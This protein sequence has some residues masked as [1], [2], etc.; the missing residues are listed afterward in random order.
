MHTLPDVVALQ[1]RQAPSDIL[2]R[3]LREQQ[4]LLDSAG[5]GILFIRHRRVVRC[6]PRYAEIFQLH[7]PQAAVGH[8]SETLH[9]SREAFRALGRAAYPVLARGETYRTE[10]QMRRSNGCLFWT[11]LTGRLINP[12]DSSEGSIWIVDDIDEQKRSQAELHAALREKQVLFDNAMVGI[13]VLRDRILARCNRHFEQ[14]LG[15][16]PGELVGR[17]SRQ[18]YLSESDWQAAGEHCYAPLALGRE[19]EGQMTLRAKDGRAVAV[20]VRSRPLDPADLSQGTLWIV[21]DVSERL[22]VQAQLA[23]MHGAL[24]QQVRDRTRELRETVAD[25]HREI[26]QRKRDQERIHWL[27][28][29][30]VL[31]GLPN[32]LL[33]TE[34][35]EQAVEAA[36]RS[37]APLS[38]IF[39]DLDNF[40]HVND[41][42]GH[43]VGDAL[44]VEMARR[45][46]RTVR[47][48][49]TVARLSGDEFVLI[50]PGANAQG[51]A[52]VAS[53]MQEAAR[54]PV[55][56]GHHEL[57]VSPSMGI[58]LFPEHGED[59]E[60]L[61]QAADTAMYRAKAE[62][63]NNFR[64]FTPRMQE[65]SAQ[66]LQLT[67]ALSRALERGQFALHYQPQVSA[68]TGAISGVE[69]LLRW[70]HPELGDISPADFIPVAE[71]SGQIVAIGEWVLDTALAQL[72]RWRQRGLSGFTMSVNLSAA[73][74][75]HPQLPELVA[76]LLERHG[77]AGDSLELELTENVA[78]GDP[79]AAA[80]I[81]D[82]LHAH[83]VGLAIDDFGTGYSSLSQLKRFRICRLK[84]D[85]SFVRD[86]GQDR[87]D[88]ALVSAIVRMAQALGMRTTAEGVETPQQL[89][90]L[91]GEGC[92]ELQGFHISRP[93]PAE[94]VEPFLLRHQRGARLAPAPSQARPGKPSP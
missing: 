4:T 8:S 91:R 63:R 25:L 84:I 5:V 9:P 69:A 51:A 90:L 78:I 75:R 48:R 54:A 38:I 29:Y 32:R 23:Q 88:H 89:E 41:S 72:Q 49:D 10:W 42:L 66:A 21:L 47:D 52:R 46:R 34:R 73:Q 14:I 79:E 82:Q 68:A 71:D 74:F 39:L 55:Q 80:R 53:K 50:L 70:R 65:Q 67:N 12:E 76:Q 93:L 94:Q 16:G 58:A 40:K 92:T 81:M 62:G 11:H 44:L 28:H 6:N 43:R 36:R 35:G 45:L 1:Q 24:E 13:V 56:L 30:D 86:L 27:A 20:E 83:G 7:S 2:K 85:R 60:S 57:S 31:T 18:W 22:R 15:Y 3:A 19:F 59:F 77:L 37:G 17:S 61:I 26:E 33:L 87:N 64:F